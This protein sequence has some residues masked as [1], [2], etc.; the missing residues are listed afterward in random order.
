M[1]DPY[2]TKLLSRM[3]HSYN[4]DINEIPDNIDTYL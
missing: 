2:D 1:T 3:K 4:I